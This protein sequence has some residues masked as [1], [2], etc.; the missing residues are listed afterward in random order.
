MWQ[1]SY[2]D[3]K[4]GNRKQLNNPKNKTNLTLHTQQSPVN[5][6]PNAKA[7]C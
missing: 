4:Y 7:Q 2:A 6:W 5:M 1:A 3:V